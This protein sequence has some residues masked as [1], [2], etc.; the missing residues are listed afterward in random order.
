MFL[1]Y[2]NDLV[3]FIAQYN[4]KIKIF[5]DDVKLYVKVVSYIAEL[6]MALSA[7]AQWADEWQLS[8]FVNKCDVLCIGKCITPAAF[9]INNVPLPMV[10]SYHDLGITVARDFI[11]ELHIR[12]IVN[13]A[14]QSP[15]C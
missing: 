3:K 2:I 8:V 5:A 15:S 13:K 9:Q 4:V 1:I 11:S 6:H 7:L 10:S 14:H 12:D